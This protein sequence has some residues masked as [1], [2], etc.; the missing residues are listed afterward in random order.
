MASLFPIPFQG[1]S[2]LI[3]LMCRHLSVSGFLSRV[4][5]SL[6][7]VD[8][9]YSSGEFRTSYFPCEPEPEITTDIQE[10]EEMGG[11]GLEKCHQ[12]KKGKGFSYKWWKSL[13]NLE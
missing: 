12:N 4:N 6:V 9:V 13:R 8:S 2:F 11:E 1:G 3:L 5:C 7:A 10:W